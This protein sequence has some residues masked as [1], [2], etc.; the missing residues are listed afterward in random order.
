M[1]RPCLG[2]SSQS[3]NIMVFFFF[4]I[5]LEDNCFTILCWLLP[6]INMNQGRRQDTTL[7]E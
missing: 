4:L 7:K 3:S 6:Y 1:K 5:L 2:K